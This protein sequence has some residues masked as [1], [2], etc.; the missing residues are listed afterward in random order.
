MDANAD[1]EDTDDNED[2]YTVTVTVEDPSG[3]SAS[4]DVVITVNNVNDAPM[5]D[6]EGDDADPTTLWVLENGVALTTDEDGEDAPL[7]GWHLRG[8]GRR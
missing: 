2:T 4:Q 8:D 7:T 6:T 1:G 3:A 5:F